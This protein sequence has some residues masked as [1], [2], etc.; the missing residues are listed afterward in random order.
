MLRVFSY[1]GG[2]QSTAVLVL[3]AEGHLDYRTFLFANTG[4]DS[5][6]PATIAYVRDHAI[7]YAQAHDLELH[8]LDR[9]RRDGTI[10]TLYGRLTR[11]GSRSLPIPVRMDN[12]A[13]GTRS[14]TAD[15]KIKVI[16]RWLKKHGATAESPAAVGIGISVDEVWRA[17]T[18]VVQP[19][20]R[21][22]Y[23]LLDLR[24][25]RADCPGIIA[26]A[27]LPVPPKSACW[28][29]PFHSP[30]TWLDMRND[31]PETFERAC[32][33]EDLLNARRDALGRD[34]VYLTRFG[35]PLRDVIPAGQDALLRAAGDER[36]GQ[37]DAGHCWT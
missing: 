18:R 6:N 10:E 21:V 2:W 8:M 9:V 30:V 16:G 7:P 20:E 32:G 29:C 31:Q 26:G 37:C 33:L 34:H 4:D 14:C 24:I 28:F 35:K 15:F 22:E 25:R 1:G 13:P 27:G 11:E 5:E 19:Y 17:S 3:A 12:G 36:D 23:P